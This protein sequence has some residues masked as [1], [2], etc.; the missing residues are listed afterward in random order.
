MDKDE[1]IAKGENLAAELETRLVD[2]ISKAMI[3]ESQVDMADFK[4]IDAEIIAQEVEERAQLS[5]LRF[6][7]QKCRLLPLDS[8]D[9][10]VREV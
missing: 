8:G 7:L 3:M 9:G 10:K 4:L 5:R 6:K 1:E 2:A